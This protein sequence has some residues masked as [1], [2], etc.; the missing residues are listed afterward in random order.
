M[1]EYG[2]NEQPQIQYA[3]ASD[4]VRIAFFVMGDGAPF[5]HMPPTPLSNIQLEWEN[6]ACRMYYQGLAAHLRLLRYDCRGAGLSDRDVT[7]YSLVKTS[8]ERAA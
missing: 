1:R 2:L 4:G 7:D 3:T 8:R 6:P 5:V